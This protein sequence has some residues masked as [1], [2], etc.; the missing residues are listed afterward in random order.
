MARSASTQDGTDSTISSLRSPL[1]PKRGSAT[2]RFAMHSV[3]ERISGWIAA[4]FCRRE[5]SG[6]PLSAFGTGPTETVNRSDS[7][8]SGAAS[9]AWFPSPE[10]TLADS[11]PQWHVKAALAGRKQLK[12]FFSVTR[13]RQVPLEPQQRTTV[14]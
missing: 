7:P 13:E 11:P 12:T 3:A 14:I 1:A 2:T 4:V 5:I 10:G 6:A 9:I 8:A